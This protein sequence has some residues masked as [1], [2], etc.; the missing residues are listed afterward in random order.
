MKI[1]LTNEQ[2]DL[3]ANA[4]VAKTR[5]ARPKV[6]VAAALD[7]FKVPRELS[8]PENDERKLF[9]DVLLTVRADL[10]AIVQSVR[11]GTRNH[12]LALSEHLLEH[13]DE[14]LA[15]A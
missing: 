11:T 5:K 12:T 2:I 9:N 1:E 14:V 6:V 3:I 13:V 7:P 4:V 8:T 15:E 10:S